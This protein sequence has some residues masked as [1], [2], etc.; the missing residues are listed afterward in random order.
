MKV[1]NNP[2]E[3]KCSITAERQSVL[4][5]YHLYKT[6]HMD[7]LIMT[8]AGYILVTVNDFHRTISHNAAGVQLSG[9]RSEMLLRWYHTRPLHSHP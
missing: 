7:V 8:H 5:I 4:L 3:S 2:I 1:Q 9:Q 6:I